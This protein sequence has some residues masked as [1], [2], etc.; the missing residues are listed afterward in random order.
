MKITGLKVFGFLLFALVAL[1]FLGG[2]VFW[3]VI[4]LGDDLDI[5]GT[6]PIVRS[7]PPGVGDTWS[8]YGG[9]GYGNRYSRAGEITPANVSDLE[10]AWQFRTGALEGRSDD[11]INRAAFETL[12]TLSKGRNQI[13][14]KKGS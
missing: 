4:G 12:E 2:S 6:A 13:D 14:H 5:D 11:V 10:I 9:D 1:T 8:A 3:S 7:A